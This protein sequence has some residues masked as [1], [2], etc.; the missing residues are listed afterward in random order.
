M[1]DKTDFGQYRIELILRNYNNI[2]L[3]T[4]QH[5]AVAVPCES[6]INPGVQVGRPTSKFYFS[7][8]FSTD[9]LVEGR[10]NALA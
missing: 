9:L 4:N 10:L 2:H 7:H 8:N 3:A 1:K 6:A 5:I